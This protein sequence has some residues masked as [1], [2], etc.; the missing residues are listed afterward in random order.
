ML[1][2]GCEAG[3]KVF[4]GG[5][6][7]H[8]KNCQYYPKSFTKIYD[9]LQCKFKILNIDSVVSWFLIY[10]GYFGLFSATMYA[11]S[12]ADPDKWFSRLFMAIVS[13]GL[14]AILK[15]L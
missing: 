12:D 10:T 11:F 14:G 5:E 7:R 1:K 8:D 3:C 2:N 9:D 6:I 15:K 13:L 4:T